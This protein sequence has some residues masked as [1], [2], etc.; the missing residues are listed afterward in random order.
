MFNV[1]GI[2]V[3]SRYTGGRSF[4]LDIIFCIPDETGELKLVSHEYGKY[5]ND[6]RLGL[7]LIL[8]ISD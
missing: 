1:F 6:I 4:N 7:C 2:T 3:L 8:L 5:K